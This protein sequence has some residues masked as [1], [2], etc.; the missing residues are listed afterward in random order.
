[1]LE[2]DRSDDLILHAD[3][4]CKSFGTI[5]VLFSVSMGVRVGEIHALIGENGAGK[6]TLMKILS[7]YHAPTTGT[8]HLDGK[9]IELPTDGQAEKL[10]IVLIHQELSLAEQLTVEE[11]IFLGR[12][13]SRYGFLN[14]THM[15]AQVR[16]LLSE[17]GLDVA[18]D[19]RISDLSIAQKQMVEI[20]KAISRNARILI[21]DEPTA[22]LT[23]AETAIFFRQI[24]SLKAQGVS[25]IFVSHK[26]DEVKEIS[27]RVT[28]LRDGQWISTKDTADMQPDSMAQLMVGRELSDLYPPKTE[29]DVDVP[30]VLRVRNLTAQGGVADVSFDLG[31]GEILG[32]AG[33]VGSGRTALFEAICGLSDVHS[34]TIEVNGRAGQFASVAQAR[35]AGLTYLTK[36]RKE[37]GLL[38]NMGMRPNLTLLALP[39]FIRR[40]MINQRAEDEA[41]VT[42]KRRF[43][44]RARDHRV[45][46]RDLSGG[47][48]QKLLLAKIM[49]S[50]P[51]I[52]VVDEPTRG[53]DVGTKQQIYHFIAALAQDG[54]SI[55]LISS[56]MP[57]VIGM[58]HRVAVMREGRLMTV[59][60]GDEINENEI[61]RYAAGLKEARADERLSA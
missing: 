55:I 9:P 58:C 2:G 29:P 20:A 50:Q 53:I 23:P 11:N 59:L 25:I 10:G 46:M 51:N 41:L 32:F 35:D 37:K 21:M 45:N 19:S 28:I 39:K 31:K 4:I 6:S 30:K 14:R 44:I 18:P 42:A 12:E 26:L 57:E 3:R 56:E 49:E 17:L 15:R 24:R 1:M 47:N 27:D 40:H 36:D 61:V 38:L 33:L 34:G 52:V 22:V 60:S 8:I 54:M 13:E 7:G 16:A 43:D 5:P 48:Q